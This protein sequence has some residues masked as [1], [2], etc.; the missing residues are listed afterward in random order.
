[1]THFVP[2][3]SKP[4]RAQLL[5]LQRQSCTAWADCQDLCSAIRPAHQLIRS[6]H[7]KVKLSAAWRCRFVQCLQLH[8]AGEASSSR[9]R[10]ASLLPGTQGKLSTL[11]PRQ[12]CSTCAITKLTGILLLPGRHSQSSSQN[13]KRTAQPQDTAESSQSEHAFHA[14]ARATQQA[15][16]RPCRA[17][18]AACAY[19]S[20]HS[21]GQSR[22]C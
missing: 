11:A 22:L 18:R 19:N 10:P 12:G 14:D 4:L 21:A 2:L 5:S 6:H 17:T 15:A 16:K 8:S 13:R 1:M 9:T 3:L 7:N 20:P